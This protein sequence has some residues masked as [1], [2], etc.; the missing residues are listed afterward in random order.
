M[1][2]FQYKNYRQLLKDYIQSQGAGAKKQLSAAMDIS[3]SMLSQILNEGREISPEHAFKISQLMK[4]NPL[5]TKHWLNLVDYCRASPG[6]LKEFYL[7]LLNA[8]ERDFLENERIRLG[9]QKTGWTDEF[10]AIF[11][12]SWHFV[13]VYCVLGIPQKWN[14]QSLAKRLNIPLSS[15]RKS[16]D[17]LK[18]YG[19]AEESASGQVRLKKTGF[20]YVSSPDSPAHW[21]ASAH[22]TKNLRAKALAVYGEE[23]DVKVKR[24]LFRTMSALMSKDDFK[25]IE[26][27]ILKLCELFQKG[28][29]QEKFEE[30]VCLNIDYFKL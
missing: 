21:A 6:E 15:S 8:S 29:S 5:E 17:V 16:I 14:E 25:K 27:E 23:R 30:V 11:Y 28:V 24:S 18:E 4:F 19:L 3:A 12:S 2:V 9:L 13:A 10:I 22:H 20:S 7:E 1:K 26:S